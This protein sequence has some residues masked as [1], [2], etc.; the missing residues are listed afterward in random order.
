MRHTL[1]EYAPA[2]LNLALSVGPPDDAFGLHPI[3]SWMVTI[4][5]MDDLHVTRLDDGSISR[6]AVQ[7]HEDAKRPV[8]VDW[9]ITDDLAVRA[10][11]ALERYTG[12]RLPVQLR[13]EKRIP[14]GGGLGGGSSDAAAMLRACNALFELRLGGDVLRHIASAIGSDIPFLVRGGS[15]IVSGFGEA[16]EQQDV[17]ADMHV[18][19][20]FPEASCPTGAV[21]TQFDA[22]GADRLDE[23]A[24]RVAVAGGPL[25]NALA[26]AA[27]A[28]A[29][30]LA[31]LQSSIEATAGRPV[32]VSGSG[33]TLFLVCDT[34]LEAGAIATAIESRH[35]VPTVPAR[36]LSTA[37][38]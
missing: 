7:W 21:Y 8:D 22:C 10:H 13:L 12:R 3:C 20:V 23:A 14:V 27:V 17:P 6:Y 28:E 18:V 29:P 36:P 19:L 26:A 35:D 33:S 15:A 30:E 16:V 24:V 4:D 11:R 31:T 25:F 1:V 5:L 38:V 9:R 37:A 34:G 2:K 32:H